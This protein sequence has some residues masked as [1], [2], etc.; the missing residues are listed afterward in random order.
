MPEMN[1]Q[2]V[3]VEMKRRRPYV[4]IIMASAYM[5][6]PESALASVDSFLTK[7]E[8]PERL[9]KRMDEL[10]LSSPALKQDV[11]AVNAP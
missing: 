3:A 5:D 7:G 1:G 9:L 4:P 2:Q 11:S 10:L 6:L 8:G